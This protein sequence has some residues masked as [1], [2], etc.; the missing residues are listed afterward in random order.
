MRTVKPIDCN[1]QI[2]ANRPTFSAGYS[3]VYSQRQVK[4][5]FLTGE[6]EAGE[7]LEGGGGFF[8]LLSPTFR[9]LPPP[10]TSFPS[11]KIF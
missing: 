6:E 5:S 2:L 10:L 4:K 8:P 3:L 9:L 1:Q 7:M 11:K